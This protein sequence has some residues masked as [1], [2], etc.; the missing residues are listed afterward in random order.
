MTAWKSDK[1]KQIDVAAQCDNMGPVLANQACFSIIAGEPKE[2]LCSGMFLVRS[3]NRTRDI[4]DPGSVLTDPKFMP[5]M[6]DQ[7]YFNQVM[8]QKLNT[9]ALDMSLFV[10]GSPYFYK[11]PVPDHGSPYLH[12][13]PP[14]ENPMAIH[15]NYHPGDSK[16]SAMR[17]HHCWFAEASDQGGSDAISA[18]MTPAAVHAAATASGQ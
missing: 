5:D 6:H 7:D 11:D 10:N 8:K 1:A 3:T 18:K 17:I 2:Y 9:A 16:R 4:F 13:Y 12:D 14:P 15:W